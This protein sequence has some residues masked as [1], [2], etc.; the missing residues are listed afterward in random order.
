MVCISDHQR[1]GGGLTEGKFVTLR[2]K[3]PIE[4]QRSRVLGRDTGRRH[5]LVSH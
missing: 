4:N 2:R 3:Y 5:G 1:P